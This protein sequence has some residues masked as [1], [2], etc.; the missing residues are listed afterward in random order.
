MIAAACEVRAGGGDEGERG[1][2]PAH[3]GP[4]RGAEQAL[5]GHRERGGWENS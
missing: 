4:A 2:A 5:A 3:G 1:E